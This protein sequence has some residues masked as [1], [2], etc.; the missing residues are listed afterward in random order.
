MALSAQAMKISP[1]ARAAKSCALGAAASS[2][3]SSRRARRAI[4]AAMQRVC[5]KHI[6]TDLHATG[7][8]R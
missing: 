4:S 1:S 7:T 5:A 2:A 3:S 8:L 6:R